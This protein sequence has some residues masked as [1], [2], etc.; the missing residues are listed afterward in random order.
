MRGPAKISYLS[1]T[2]RRGANSLLDPWSLGAQDGRYPTFQVK[3]I[4][5][6][7]RR[8][9]VVGVK[10]LCAFEVP[11]C[12]VFFECDLQKSLW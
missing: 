11:V 7:C 5:F 4:L 6:D 12:M 2:Q 9:V 10:F 1:P 3:T 8:D